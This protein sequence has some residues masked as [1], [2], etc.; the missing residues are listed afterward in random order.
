MFAIRNSRPPRRYRSPVTNANPMVAADAMN[1][2]TASSSF[3][4][5]VRSA[6]APITGSTKTVRN[7]DSETTYG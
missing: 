5:G 6:T 3:L 7:T 2:V 1:A 4:R